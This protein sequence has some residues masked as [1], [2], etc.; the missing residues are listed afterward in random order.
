MRREV[1]D[2]SIVCFKYDF[3]NR[4]RFN[5]EGQSMLN[6]VFFCLLLTLRVRG[7]GGGEGEA[8]WTEELG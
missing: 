3:V 4:L 1:I 7:V 8:P 2:G 5:F 6:A